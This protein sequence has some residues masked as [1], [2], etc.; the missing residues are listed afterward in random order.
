MQI[1]EDISGITVL[2]ISGETRVGTSP[3]VSVPV[4]GERIVEGF[5]IWDPHRSKMAALLIKSHLAGTF[6]RLVSDLNLTPSSK[7]LYLGAATGTTASHFSDL[8][9]AGLVYAVE[10]SARSMRDLL[11]LCA[12]RDNIIPILE[13][14]SSPERYSPILEPVDLVYQDVAQRN[15]AEIANR[16]VELYLKGGG[17][18]VLMIKARS[19]DVTADPRVVYK[20]EVERLGGVEVISVA[21]LRPYHRDHWAVVARRVAES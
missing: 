8:V 3:K 15:Q 2:D 7:V 4:Y 14:A 1:L 10:F 20:A 16:N 13:D 9:P 19:I 11:V 12:A 21:D 6:K 17:A 5:R 18:L